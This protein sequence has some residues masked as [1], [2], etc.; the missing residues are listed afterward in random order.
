MLWVM[1]Y[2]R[3]RLIS[4]FSPFRNFHNYLKLSNSGYL[5]DTPFIFDRC[6]RSWA[7][8]TPDKYKRDSKY[9]NNTFDKSKFSVT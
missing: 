6:H 3:W 2:A 8:V 1:L 4:Q 9:L 5:Y 7:A